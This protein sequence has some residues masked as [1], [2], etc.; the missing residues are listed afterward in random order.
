MNLASDG[1]LCPRVRL[2][3]A[4]HMALQM[5]SSLV[6]RGLAASSS[7]GRLTKPWSGLNSQK[8]RGS[9]DLRKCEGAR[10]RDLQLAGALERF[11]CCARAGGEA[12]NGGSESKLES[13]EQEASYGSRMAGLFGALRPFSIGGSCDGSCPEVRGLWRE[14]SAGLLC[15]CAV[16]MPGMASL[17]SV[18]ASDFLTALVTLCGALGILQFFDELAKRDLLEKVPL[19]LPPDSSG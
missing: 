15:S 3:C 10:K 1:S 5:H 4:S 13:C 19:S 11:A 7:S 6:G 18:A 8:L 14:V 17:E 16:A 2:D 12:G 9:K